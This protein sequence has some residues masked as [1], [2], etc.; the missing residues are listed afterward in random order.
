MPSVSSI[1]RCGI[2]AV[3][4]DTGEAFELNGR[5]QVVVDQD[6]GDRVV[7]SVVNGEDQLRHYMGLTVFV[8]MGLV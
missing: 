6:R 1:D 5:F 8:E 7:R 4:L 2:A 3:A